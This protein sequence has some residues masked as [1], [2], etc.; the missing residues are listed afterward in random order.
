[1]VIIKRVKDLPTGLSGT[2]QAHV[3]Q[4]SQLV[5]YGGFG[6]VEAISQRIDA[7]LTFN[8]K[9]DNAYPAGVAEGAEELRKL[10]GREFGKLHDI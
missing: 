10:N 3:P 1:M 4:A 5:R 7:H 8:Q 9:A 2:E 6:H